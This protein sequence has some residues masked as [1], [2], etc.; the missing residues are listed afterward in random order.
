MALIFVPPRPA[1][2]AVAARAP[3]TVGTAADA[4]TD[5]GEDEAIRQSASRRTD[6]WRPWKPTNGP[7]ISLEPTAPTST[8]KT[9]APRE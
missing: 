9:K 2:T 4:A 7:S 6:A 5:L 3:P 8:G 1:D